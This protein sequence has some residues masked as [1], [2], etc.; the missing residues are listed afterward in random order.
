MLF[1]RMKFK[2][3]KSQEDSS[4]PNG[5][6][7]FPIQVVSSITGTLFSSALFAASCVV[8]PAPEPDPDPPGTDDV[9][10]LPLASINDFNYVGGF[11]MPADQFGESSLNNTDAVF[12]TSGQS[13]FIVGHSREDAIAEFVIPALVNTN[14]ISQLPSSGPPVQNFTSVLNR[15]NTGNPDGIDT[16]RGLAIYDD[17]LIVN[18]IKYYDASTS[19]NDT[20]LVLSQPGNLSQSSVTGFLELPGAAR[21]A[22]WL[23]EM[24]AAWRDE[25][26]K[27]HL[28]G[29]SSGYP[30]ITRH[31]VGPSFHAIDASDIVNAT[32]ESGQIQSQEL[33][34]FSFSTALNTDL[35]N[36]SRN[37]DLWTALSRAEY[38]FIVPGTRTYATFGFT[39]GIDGGIG[40]KVEND[41]GYTCGGY[42]T[43]IAS[44]NYNY[45]WLWDMNDLLEVRDGQ[46]ESHDIQPYDY[47]KFDVPFQVS[48]LGFNP[49]GG[50]SFDATT[51]TLYFAVK[52][53]NANWAQYQNPP[54]VVA[55]R[56]NEY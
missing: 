35:N 46:R 48:S 52:E 10:S 32:P 50:G 31:S 20:T 17:Q 4:E 12:T 15:A 44:D 43:Y 11:T 25:L 21:S 19:V 49:I 34:E 1:N 24:P 7:V 41:N 45:Y 16:I 47:G 33:M 40:Y 36:D 2:L 30:I 53:A 22:G 28:M 3:F 37:N 13:L 27:T 39:G 9:K 18:A 23:N 55:F 29:S 8:E 6:N 14:S 38:G 51:N 56:V 26:G 54:V 5:K 42:C